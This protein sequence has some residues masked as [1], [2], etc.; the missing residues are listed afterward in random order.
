MLSKKSYNMP[1]KIYFI[2]YLLKDIN[3]SIFNIIS[4]RKNLSNP[5][6]ESVKKYFR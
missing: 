2:T 3:Y 1:N 5:V 4:V 6:A